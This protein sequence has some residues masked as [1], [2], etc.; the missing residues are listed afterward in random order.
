MVKDLL[1]DET[2]ALVEQW[3]TAASRTETPADR[4][5]TGPLQ[6]LIEDPDGAA[7]T[8]RFVDRVARPDNAVAAHQLRTVV[9]SGRLPAFLSPF[10]RI[11]LRL[12]S[13]VATRLPGVVMPLARRRMRQ[14]VGHL[15]VDADPDALA[16][17]L[18]Q[19]INS[20]FSQ[21]VNLL[22]EAVLGER[23]ADRR[24]HTTAALLDQP[25]ID[26]VSIKVSAVASQLNYWDWEGSVE[27]VVERLRVLFGRAMS[28]SP[29]TFVNLDMEEYHDLELTVAAFT[30]VLDEPQFASLDAG[31]VLQAYLPDAFP[32]LRS[33]VHWATA[34]RT[35]GGGEIKIRLVKGANL[36]MERVDAA[37][38]GWEQ[39]PYASKREVDANYKRCLD[40][41]LTPE[42]TAAVRIGVASHNLFDVAWANLLGTERDVAHRLDFEMLQGMA[43]AQSRIVKEAVEGDQL[44]LYTPIVAKHDFDVAISY[45]FRRLEENSAEGNFM[46][47]LFSLEPGTDQ[48]D[49]EVEN[50]RAALADRLTVSSTPRRSQDRPSFEAVA[51]RG[52]EFVHEPDTDPT[53]A[54]N[55]AWAREVVSTR[56]APISAPV[57]DSDEQVDRVVAIARSATWSE[58]PAERRRTI[59]HRVADQLARRRGD[60][61]SAMVH[62]GQKTFAQADPEVSEAIDFARFYGDRAT[63][64]PSIADARFTPLGVVAVIP[65]WNFPV[66]IPTGGVMAALAAGN[67]VI[68]KPSSQT[69]RC[70]EIVAECAWA[71]GVPTDAL[72]FIRIKGRD[73]GRRLVTSVDGVILTGSAET[74]QMFQSWKPDLK[75][76][77]ETS[78][79]NAMIITPHADMDL[80]VAD[81][82]A[83]AFGH[84][85]QKCSAASLAICVGD[86][87]ESP[88][89]RRQ[90]TDAVE[91][92][93]VGPAA[94][95]S[96]TIGPT[97]LPAEGKLERGLHR[98]DHGERWLVP[99]ERL[100]DERRLW[101]PGVRVGVEPGSWFHQTECFGPVL[102]IMHARTLDE[103]IAMQNA[104]EYGL[105]GG[106]HTLDPAEVDTWLDRVEVGNAYVNRVITGA[107]VRRQPFGGW[108]KSNVGP[109]AKAGG[110]NYV[111][112]LG[113][114]YPEPKSDLASGAEKDAHW[115]KAE[116]G[117]QHDP[118]GLFCEANIFRYR[119]LER[120][121]IRVGPGTGDDELQRVEAAARCCGVP[122]EV[123]LSAT[124]SDSAFAARVPDLGVERVRVL[125]TVSDSVR[126][127][128]AQ[129][130]VYLADAPVTANGRL[131]L[132]HYLREQAISRT[133]HRFGNLVAVDR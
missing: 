56:P 114:W 3:L 126:E 75:L 124:E 51:S 47:V 122:M 53:L 117:R 88:R 107:I 27:R 14:L 106:I 115:W 87:Y 29:R 100:D 102:G 76:F 33:L 31:I 123:S 128:A 64:L 91:S 99:P 111:M 32:N 112:Q 8:M 2:I 79:K 130:H 50:F 113:T 5:T 6:D 93:D 103:A 54:S 63:D 19:R 1:A 65:P 18:Q 116:F 69:P 43:P 97:I 74:A 17:H 28:T 66:A 110:P 45:L 67:A 52:V 105:T 119:P 118:T 78:G 90:L 61:I 57:F 59:L 85:G 20:G 83:S 92:L 7:F 71:G 60:L 46:R 12:G 127:A 121:V 94:A 70:A 96:T 30:R 9:A 89:F 82:V 37:I 40:W 36:A 101:R 16:Q 21:N 22:G 44:L 13:A 72:R 15:V 11:L 58:M 81:L 68:F 73:V 55:R 125:G 120:I 86:V 25:Q 80:A 49:L 84:A 132:L 98:L 104:S 38:H 133:L 108:K 109:G 23:E 39:A 95:M 129:A 77:A 42:R 24:L 41:V 62:E 48:F 26:Y 35:A 34:R 4:A 131:E 10:D